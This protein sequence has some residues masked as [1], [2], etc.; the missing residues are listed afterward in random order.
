MHSGRS[1]NKFEPPSELHPKSNEA[2]TKNVAVI[3]IART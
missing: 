2:E 3:L 1:S